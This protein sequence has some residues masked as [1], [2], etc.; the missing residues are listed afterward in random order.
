MW[1]TT[2]PHQQTEKLKKCTIISIDAE[3]V[4]DKIQHLFMIKN[5]SSPES[6]CRGNLLP[7]SKVHIWQIHSKNHSQWWK[8][9]SIYSKIRN[10]TK[11]PTIATI[12]Q[13]KVLAKAIREEKEINPNWKSKTVAVSDG[14]ILCIENPKDATRKTTRAH[15][16]IEWSCRIKN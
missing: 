15:Q 13:Q 3:K 10:K 4:F 16:W 14:M 6:G 9:E 7:H 1:Y 2:M 8:T 5:K 11:M 12:S